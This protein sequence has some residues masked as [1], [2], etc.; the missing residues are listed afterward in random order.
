MKTRN[1]NKLTFLALALLVFTSINSYAASTPIFV[2][3][4]WL[5]KH[6]NDKHVIVVDMT[7]GGMQYE[8][9][10]IPGAI[11]LGYGEIIK[12]RKDRVSVRLSNDQ[13]AKVLG[14]AGI[15]A[16]SHVVIYDDMG[17]M[18]AGRLFWEMERIGHNK[19]S[20]VQGGLVTWILE[21]RK[22]TNKPTARKPVTHTKFT[23]VRA[24]EAMMA[25]VIKASNDKQITLLDVRSDEEYLGHPRMP[26]SGHIPGAKWW[27]WED[28]VNFEKGFT[29]VEAG[30]INQ[31]LAKVGVKDKK[32]PVIVYC[33]SGHRASQAYLTLRSLG[34]ENVKLYDGSMAEYA[35]VKSN[36]LVLGKQPK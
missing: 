33:R 26:R 8:R 18:N 17:G 23:A 20:V 32:Q 13:L 3:T 27:P 35:R 34:Y 21:H 15:S 30:K 29:L 10:H 9:F 12:R 31:A 4:D 36:P 28:N 16:D 5:A 7:M 2:S 1:S 25:D 22:V 24:N 11:R 19:V 14:Q 6:M